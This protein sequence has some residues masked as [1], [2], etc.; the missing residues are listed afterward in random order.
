M[1]KHKLVKLFATIFCII[2]AVVSMAQELPTVPLSNNK[3]QVDGKNY[4]IHIVRKGET[5]FAISRTYKVPVD[6]IKKDNLNL[7]N[8]LNINQHLKVRINDD[9]TDQAGK[10]ILHTVQKGDTPT[11]IAKRYNIKIDDIYKLNPDS[12]LSIRIGE[13]LKI[14]V[15]KQLA[16]N[17]TEEDNS[18]VKADTSANYFMYKVRKKETK[19]GLAHKY[20]I[21]VAELDELNNLQDRQLQ[22]GEYIKLPIKTATTQKQDDDTYYHKVEPKETVYSL[23]KKYDISKRKFYKL[24]PIVKERGLQI[25][26]SVIIPKNDVS[27]NIF[28]TKKEESN[29]TPEVTAE[30]NNKYEQLPLTDTVKCNC[31]TDKQ[32]IHKIA[33]FLP[34]YLNVNDTLGDYE[35]KLKQEWAIKNHKSRKPKL[36]FYNRTKMFLEFYQ[37]ALL[38]LNDLKKQGMSFEVRVFDTRNDSL[39]VKELLAKNNLS[40]YDLFIGPFYSSI[41]NIVNDYA[42]ENKIN[43]VSPL[44]LKKSFIEHNPYAFQ[45]SPPF[46]VQMLYASEYLN[47]FDTKNYVVI[48]DGKDIHQ[49]YISAFKRE[50][51]SHINETNYTQVKYNELFYYQA[52]DSV[53]KQAFTPKIKN[54]IVIPSNNRAFVS[55]VIGKLNGY[56]YHYDIVTFGQPRWMYFDNIELEYF[57]NTNTRFFSNSYIDYS[58]NNVKDFVL[59][60]RKFYKTEPKKYS[61][62]GY[63][64]TKYFCSALNMYGF[65]FRKCIHKH[66]PELLQTHFNFV[67]YSYQGG[68]QNTGIYILE[69]SKENKL[70]KSAEY[71]KQ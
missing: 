29:I 67:P 59:Q 26:E 32:N 10:Y 49:E 53:L 12:E 54:I 51:Y 52:K 27:D 14:P 60:Y 38:A 28:A 57:H 7:T 46:E 25:G 56:A 4:Y 21:T 45:V 6:T 41:L 17:K 5:L 43:I 50:L 2:L 11:N 24:N 36:H 37:G 3:V 1:I 68:Y 44:S 48:H 33:F 22:V 18:L 42:W 31:K 39:Y 19:Y 15:N 62:Q 47:N 30:E 65:D 66:K 58:R 40:D 9:L 64:I 69:Y 70:I 55:D 63:D 61:F 8:Q 23:T 16:K 20:N 35:E 34:V 13:R 71:P